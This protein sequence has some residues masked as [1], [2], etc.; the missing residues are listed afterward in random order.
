MSHFGGDDSRAQPDVL[1]LH[2]QLDVGTGT[3]T[4]R[5]GSQPSVGLAK[6]LVLRRTVARE[7]CPMDLIAVTS[8]SLFAY[9]PGGA[10][11]I[12]AVGVAVRL[13]SYRRRNRD[14]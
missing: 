10:G 1:Q 2:P 8:R 11:V 3:A 4:A 5:D 6:G 7:T 14:R 9:G 13:L 12:I